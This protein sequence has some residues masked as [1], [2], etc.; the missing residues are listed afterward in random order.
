MGGILGS[1]KGHSPLWSVVRR[2]NMIYRSKENI[3][4][5]FSIIVYDK[6]VAEAYAEQTSCC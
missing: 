6:G 2:L 4:K 1:A 3:I 5:I